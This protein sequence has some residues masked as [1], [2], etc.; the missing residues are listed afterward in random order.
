MAS[1]RSLEDGP[2]AASDVI[3]QTRDRVVGAGVVFRS[4]LDAWLLICCIPGFHMPV[5]KQVLIR[6]RRMSP[7]VRWFTCET[8][9]SC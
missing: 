6:G 8:V 5:S 3:V 2:V 4:T 1:K 9:A 7:S